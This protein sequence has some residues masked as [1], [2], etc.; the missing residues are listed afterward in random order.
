VESKEAPR[1]S[2]EAETSL[3]NSLSL[4]KVTRQAMR[5][6][7][8]KIIVKTLQAHNWNRRRAATALDISYRALL[9]KLKEAG[10][11]TRKGRKGLPATEASDE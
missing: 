10:L 2:G 1:H 5:D 11:P 7:E 8:S 3:D 4:K 9:Y 6:L